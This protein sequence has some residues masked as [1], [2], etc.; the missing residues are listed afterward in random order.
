MYCKLGKVCITNWSSFVLLQINAN[1]VTNWGNFIVTNWGSCYKL[2]Q[3]LL[4]N[5]AAITN[6]GKI[7]YKL[8]QVLQITAIIT[9]WGITR[10]SSSMQKRSKKRELS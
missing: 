7:F 4:Q 10:A 3:P 9:N 5:R 6:W 2:G 8:G 1:V